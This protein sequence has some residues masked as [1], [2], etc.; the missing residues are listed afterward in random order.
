MSIYV[1]SFQTVE[2][3]KLNNSHTERYVCF[4]EFVH[5]L[6]HIFDNPQTAFF[7]SQHISEL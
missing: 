5:D 2:I 3:S 1:N 7:N 4:K 6:H